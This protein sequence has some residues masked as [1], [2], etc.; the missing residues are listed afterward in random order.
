MK[1]I[2]LIL[3]ILPLSLCAQWSKKANFPDY[4]HSTVSFSVNNY[5]YV[6]GGMVSEEDSKDLWKYDPAEDTWEL[7]DSF[8]AEYRWVDAVSFV[9]GEKAY[10]YGE[11]GVST[12][13]WEYSP[14][15]GN[16]VQRAN[17]PQH[18][19]S[20]GFSR[21]GFSI[22]DYGYL[23]VSNEYPGGPGSFLFRYDPET[24]TWTERAGCPVE[25]LISMVGF[26]LKGKGYVGSG[27]KKSSD[28]NHEFWK[29]D[30]EHDQWSPISDFPGET[31][32]GAV[33]FTIGDY[34]Y[35]GLGQKPQAITDESGRLSDF[36]RY[37]SETD[38]WTQIDSCGYGAAG[39]F[40]FTINGKGYVG[41]G[42]R[43]KEEFWEY[44][45]ILSSGN[46]NNKHKELVVYPNPVTGTIHWNTNIENI[47]GIFI[48]DINGRVVRSSG[49][50]QNEM[51]VSGLPHGIYFLRIESDKSQMMQK[52][53]IQN[54][55]IK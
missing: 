21:I 35:V 46:I 2:I 40:S 32:T 37:D 9:I 48:T 8:P 6:G 27:L 50:K 42:G 4:R 29:Y 30:P 54:R 22:G 11:H 53:I 52:I 13:L 17:S 47:S 5:G 1:R 16:W 36:W 39:A 45:P 12:N 20:A 7:S 3:L 38:S 19:S 14:K 31:R 44:T 28:V 23:Y 43:Q 51:N 55:Q 41:G 18:N 10:V 26:S 49:S 15:T 25:R 24:D 34:G 33:A